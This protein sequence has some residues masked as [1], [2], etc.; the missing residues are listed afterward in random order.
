MCGI[1]GIFDC[2][3]PEQAI[4]RLLGAMTAEQRHRGPDEQGAVAVEQLGAG[5][6]CARLSIVDLEHGHQPAANEDRTV[7]AVLNGEVYNRGELQQ[8]LEGQGH[9]FVGHSDTEVLVH[10][11]EELGEGFVERLE[12]MFGLAV[13]DTRRRRLLLARDGVGI[14]P[15]LV[16][17]TPHGFLFASEAKALF[18]TGWIAPAPDLDALDTLLAAGYAPAPMS[19]FRGIRKLRAGEMLTAD[20]G[21]VRTK[22]FWRFLYREP[23]VRS[24]EEYSERLDGLLRRSVERH[25]AADVPVGA[26]LSG[27][28]DSSLVA[29]FAARTAGVRLQTFS[30]VF[31]EDPGM[32][33]SRYSRLM[34][35]ELGSEHHEIEFSAEKLGESLPLLVRALEEPCTTAPGGIVYQLAAFAARQVKAVVS[36]EGADELFG[37]YEWARLDSPYWLRRVLPAGPFRQASEVVSHPRLRRALRILGAPSDVDADLE[38]RRA[39]IPSQKRRILKPEFRRDGP[40]LTPLRPAHETLASCRDS[41]QRRLGFDFTARLSEG[42]LYI[43]DRV[44]MAH[45][46]EVRVPF[47]DKRVVEFALE[48]P[49]HWKIHRGREKRILAEI[50]R[51]H[52]PSA[53]AARRKQGL[54]Y[55]ARLWMREPLRRLAR[56]ILLDCRR[57]GPFDGAGLEEHLKQAERHPHWASRRIGQTVFL[58]CWWN[59]FIS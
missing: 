19:V 6:A 34:A 13:L 16:A 29:A 8:E 22:K 57:D 39:L 54:G 24:G 48:L 49:S 21:G 32:D 10:L 14:K 43:T 36:G 18:A 28:W 52:L 5:V 51:R 23:E 53:I 55:P 11:Y 31:P 1:A 7:F 15:L 9:R 38:W 47:L 37:G 30:I 35:K 20:C 12:G 45:S 40:D 2:R 4:L 3:L 17:E 25:L 56:E 59:E 42:I 27:G 58:Q 50:A 46:L 44:S 26:F 33:E 41:L